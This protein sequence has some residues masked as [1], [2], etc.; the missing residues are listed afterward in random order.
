MTEGKS[1]GRKMG[2]FIRDALV[3]SATTLLSFALVALTTYAGTLAGLSFD[4]SGICS[5]TGC[6]ADALRHLILENLKLVTGLALLVLFLERIAVAALVDCP[7][8]KREAQERQ[9]W[10]QE[11]RDSL[12]TLESGIKD[13]IDALE[14]GPGQC[15]FCR[16]R[17]N[18]RGT[19]SQR[20]LTLN[21]GERDAG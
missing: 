3:M 1:Y 7:R 14:D 5:D 9:Q 16:R 13:R 10:Q 15:C 17:R 18:R 11:L 4:A 6:N 8:Q 20:H 2:E 12:A 21:R 19:S